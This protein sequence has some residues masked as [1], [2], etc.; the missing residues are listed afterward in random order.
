MSGQKTVNPE[1]L[2]K[3]E[4]V[5]FIKEN[6]KASFR[7][8]L[9]GIFIIILSSIL[10]LLFSVSGKLWIIHLMGFSFSMIGIGLL[11]GTLISTPNITKIREELNEQT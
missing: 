1:R 6:R 9:F 8:I 4:L 11:L 7:I 2:R 3:N 10:E 5:F